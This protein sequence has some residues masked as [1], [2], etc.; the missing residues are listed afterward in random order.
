VTAWWDRRAPH[1]TSQPGTTP[2]RRR[3]GGSHQRHAAEENSDRW[4]PLTPS[5]WAPPENLKAPAA[6]KSSLAS[7]LHSPRSTPLSDSSRRGGGRA[8]S[9][10]T[11]RL[12]DSS[13]APHLR[14]PRRRLF[15]SASR[16]TSAPAAPHLRPTTPPPLQR[17]QRAGSPQRPPRHISDYLAASST[18]SASRY[19]SAC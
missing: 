19:T 8:T 17:V 1:P 9:P 13:A 5:V 16:S 7:C 14:L 4:G 10:T 18:S 2:G 3:H 12:S 11:S 15:D 6:F